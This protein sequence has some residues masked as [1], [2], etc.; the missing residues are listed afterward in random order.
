ML[1]EQTIEL[2]WCGL[3]GTM[4]YGLNVVRAATSHPVIDFSDVDLARFRLRANDGTDTYPT[5]NI[6]SS[7]A[8][9]ATRIWIEHT[10]VSNDFTAVGV[11]YLFAQLSTD[12]GVT[13]V[14]SGPTLL[15]VVDSTP[16]G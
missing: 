16:P 15:R 12:G 4:T 13:W 2:S 9:T 1:N 10:L 3:G 14:E 7:P 5:A 11:W 6:L 8:A